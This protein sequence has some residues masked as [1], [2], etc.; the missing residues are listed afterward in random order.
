MLSY[1][2]T[3]RMPLP[4]PRA[5]GNSGAAN[6]RAGRDPSATAFVAKV[7][8][9]AM[10]AFTTTT[11]IVTAPATVT[12]PILVA[13][14]GG[15]GVSVLAVKSDQWVASRRARRPLEGRSARP[16]G[17][18]RLNSAHALGAW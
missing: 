14:I 4:P 18:S 10:A 15:L 1:R 2:V 3:N 13:L 16:R 5:A 6:R 11:L 8:F 9:V 17:R 7:I 12:V